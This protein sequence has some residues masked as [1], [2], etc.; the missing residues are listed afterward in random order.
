[1]LGPA[2]IA[3]ALLVLLV[4][5][6]CLARPTPGPSGVPPLPTRHVL[7]NGVR[8]VIEE[9]R[10]SEVVAL[11]LWV[12]AGGRDEASSE[13]GLAHY[14]E[15]MLFKGTTL[16]PTGFIDREVEGVGGRMNAGTSLDYT[17]YQMLLPAPRALAGIETLADIS[18]NA[19]LD[20]TQLERE[21]RVVLEELRLG[22]D[23]PSR[24]LMR[25]LYQAAFDGHPYGRPVIGRVD[26]IRNLTRGQL[27]HFYRSHYVPEAFTLV[28]VGA[29][30]PPAVLDA[31]ARA[32]G[33]LPRS[34]TGRLPP[35][36]VG[37]SR[38][39][40]VEL[41]RPGTHAYLG[42]AW[43]APRLDHAETPAVDLLVSIL[44][45]GRSARL[46]QALRE[47]HGLVNTIGVAYAPLEAAGVI[48][49]T[50]QLPPGNLERA[51]AEI[52]SQLRRVRDHGIKGSE[53]ERVLTAERA[54]HEF[55]MERVEDR[56]IALGR[57]DT[58]WT[59]EDELAYLDRLRSVTAE[60]IQA[61]ARRYMDPERFVRVVLR[62]ATAR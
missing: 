12:R 53:R 61:A 40:V 24:L 10:S 31:A 6:G 55:R 50:A 54:Q 8:V 30:S 17:S 32:F 46:T 56:A 15:H 36:A 38:P 27:L 42:L 16:R 21:K 5:S 47:R 35:P 43:A 23:S 26:L 37:A 39:R 58:I 3:S 18:V 34:G 20:E 62:P 1:M 25:Q 7:P 13:L 33:G 57:A 44:G 9:H 29:V 48:T 11:Q 19:S 59:L 60:Q 4:T 41:T 28:V 22:E 52:L 45:H 14:L 49:V 2:R 51:E